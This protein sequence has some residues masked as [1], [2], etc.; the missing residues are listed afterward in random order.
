M[1]KKS[2]MVTAIGALTLL[3]TSTVV[4]AEV[5]YSDLSKEFSGVQYQ[6]VNTFGGPDWDGIRWLN[7]SPSK[8]EISYTMLLSDG[9]KTKHLIT[10][11]HSQSNCSVYPACSKQLRASESLTQSSTD[12]IAFHRVS[13]LRQ[14]SDRSN[15]LILAKTISMGLRSGL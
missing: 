11:E 13:R 4:L 6:Y 8:V 7:G 12:C 3:V 14:A 15:C 10:L 1:S 2:V 9:S 5:K